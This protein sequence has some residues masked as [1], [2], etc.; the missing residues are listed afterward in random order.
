[1]KNIIYVL[2]LFLLF[3]TVQTSNAQDDVENLI[4][5]MLL[6][7]DNFAAP[8]AEGA[9]IQSSAGWFSSASALG[10]WKFEF[11]VH[12]NA[13]F[14]P[15]SKQTKLTSNND[16]SVIRLRDNSEALVPTVF[17]GATG[18]VFE[19]EIENPLG[20]GDIPFN[21]DAIAGLDKNILAHPFAQVTV[22]L[23]FGTEAAVRFLPEIKID[24][25][26]FSTYGFGL[27]HNFNQYNK[28][29]QPR[30]IQFAAAVTYSNFML[31]YAFVP[32]VVASEVL[33]MNRINVEA[34]LWLAQVLASKLYEQFEIFGAAGVTRST[35]DYEMGGTG[36]V[37]DPLNNSLMELG[38]AELK[39][40][41]DLGFNYYFGNFKFSTML[42]AS[43]FFNANV[44]LHY[45]FGNY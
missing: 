32:I 38:D 45:R 34:D 12:A 4:T 9:A 41:G 17:G 13:L 25:V 27:K 3:L 16:F 40:K 20:G 15:E 35:F 14:I 23:P 6:V 43:N 36:F 19:G 2:P 1:M 42:T 26:G 44:G 30:D 33:E 10:E 18:I 28:F 5:D 39:F 29:S 11:S 8:G 22:G 37:L 31:D 7:A 21:F 24:D